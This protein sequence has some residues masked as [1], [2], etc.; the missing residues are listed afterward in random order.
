M[1]PEMTLAVGEEDLKRFQTVF[2]LEAAHCGLMSNMK[3]DRVSPEA[4]SGPN[5]LE[6]FRD[7][8]QPP[9]LLLAS[10]REEE[11]KLLAPLLPRLLTDAPQSCI[12]LAPR[13]LHRVEAWAEHFK[14]L[15]LDY[16]RRGA[17]QKFSAGGIVLWDSFGELMQLY[18]L[19]S[20]VFVGGSLAPL[21]G[22][23]FLEPL[24]CGLVPLLGPSWSNFAWVGREI[25]ELGL[26]R[27]TPDPEALARA[28]L[29][30]LARPE[31]KEEIKRRF[32]EY[33]TRRKGGARM[34][35]ELVR[36]FLGYN[37]V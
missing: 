8:E 9:L 20:A 17:L 22:Q 23:N 15:S 5:P 1:Q 33:L 27:R 29:E 11:E 26:A 7:R 3:F 30:G 36:R 31:A 34:A 35:A 24:S 21:G 32:A 13:H 25:F 14:T 19:A 37:D 18:R 28:L 12:V 16:T 2:G 6:H 4:E 10:V